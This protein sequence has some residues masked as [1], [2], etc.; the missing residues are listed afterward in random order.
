MPVIDLSSIVLV[1]AMLL[2]VL[3]MPGGSAAPATKTDLTRGLQVAAA[4]IGLRPG[5]LQ[6]AVRAHDRAVEQGLTRSA[7]LTVIDYSLPSRERRLWVLDLARGEVL[8]QELV[9]H[10]RATGGDLAGWFSN[11]PGSA[12]SSLG[13]FITGSTYF[14]KHGLSLRLRG[15]DR[16]VNDRAESRAIVVHGADYVSEASVRALGRLGRSL[17]C[18]ALG[19]AVAPRIIGLIRGGTLL[20]A[21]HP[22]GPRA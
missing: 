3:P 20:Y 13:S 4:S 18:P 22:S 6:V 9:A 11:R 15:V 5:V 14:G 10:G 8:A 19:T 16:G 7:I 2:R 12:A 21:Y 17:G 1:L